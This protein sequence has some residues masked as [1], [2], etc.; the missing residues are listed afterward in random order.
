[1]KQQFHVAAECLNTSKEQPV[2]LVDLNGKRSAEAVRPAT[3]ASRQ[4]H[5]QDQSAKQA[6]SDME[7]AIPT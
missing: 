6:Q 5:G 4:L 3:P 2:E 7:D 1:M